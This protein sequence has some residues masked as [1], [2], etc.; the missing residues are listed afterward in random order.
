[1]R[2]AGVGGRPESAVE[3]RVILLGV[4]LEVVVDEA[5]GV[6]AAADVRIIL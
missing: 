6:K 3:L 5:A 4:V 1:M 2:L